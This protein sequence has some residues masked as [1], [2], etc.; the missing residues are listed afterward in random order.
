MPQVKDCSTET[1]ADPAI[2]AITFK[3]YLN[4]GQIV[5]EASDQEIVGLVSEGKVVILKGAFD[6]QLML[7]YRDALMRWARD[8]ATFAHGT[9]PSVIPEMN[10]HRIDDGVIKSVCPH[11]F[12][13]F[14]FN[15][16][17]KLDE[18]LGKPSKEIAES[19]RVL[20]NKV[21]GTNFLLSLTGLR[22]KIL[23]YPSGAGFLTEHS[24]PLEPQ[25]V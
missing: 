5:S 8:N 24:H 10:F 25:R 6:R 19:M 23:H 9:S 17:E 21:A 16:I 13:Q 14:G 4:K 15:T 3:S 18:Y 22:L 12:H 1:S 2:T 20:Q 7:E 11:V